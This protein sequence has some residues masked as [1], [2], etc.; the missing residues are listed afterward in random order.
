[1]AQVTASSMADLGLA[2]AAQR[3]RFM[4]SSTTVSFRANLFATVQAHV[5]AM[6][7]PK[8]GPAAPQE[9]GTGPA[10]ISFC[11]CASARFLAVCRPSCSALRK[12]P[13][14]I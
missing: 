9:S 11:G 6:R 10:A 5:E 7:I 12:I 2:G 14:E 4:V 1:M 8:D 13:T 3:T